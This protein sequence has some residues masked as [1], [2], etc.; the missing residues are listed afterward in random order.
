MNVCACVWGA[1]GT[2]CT[3]YTEISVI[4]ESPDPSERGGFGLGEM[5]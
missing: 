4:S 2:M 5:E 3:E 1:G